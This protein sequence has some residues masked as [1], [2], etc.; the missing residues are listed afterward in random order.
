[1]YQTKLGYRKLL[2][3]IIHH[4][5]GDGKIEDGGCGVANNGTRVFDGAHA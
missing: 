1:M 3:G 4:F 5:D 2:E